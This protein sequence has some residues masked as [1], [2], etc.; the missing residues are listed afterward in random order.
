MLFHASRT[1]E[2]D[3]KFSLDFS[4]VFIFVIFDISI[5]EESFSDPLLKADRSFLARISELAQ[6]EMETVKFEKTKK[7]KR[8]KFPDL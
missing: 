3:I 1:A 6:L 7:L 4:Y 8:K 5:L 2:G